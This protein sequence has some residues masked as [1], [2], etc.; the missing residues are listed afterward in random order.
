MPTPQVNI[1]NGS[2]TNP[3]VT[4]PGDFQWLNPTGTN[5]LLTNCGGFCTQDSYR[6]PANS[7]VNAQ[8]IANPTNNNFTETPNEWNAP[9]MPHIKNPTR[10]VHDEKEVA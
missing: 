6:V 8:T 3:P 2:V 4:Y 5:V 1:Q 10:G 9:G 7:T